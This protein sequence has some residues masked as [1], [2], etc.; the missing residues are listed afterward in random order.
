[1]ATI[2]EIANKLGV[3]K[4]TVSKALKNS[5]DLN[6]DTVA[7]IQKAAAEMG[8]VGRK[9]IDKNN[10]TI[11]LIYPELDD[12]LYASMVRLLIKM[13]EKDGFHCIALPHNFDKT[14]VAE[15]LSFLIGKKVCG[16]FLMADKIADDTLLG[17]RISLSGIPVV[18]IS[19]DDE[20]AAYDNVWINEK[21]G[22]HHVVEHLVSLGHEKIAFIG[23]QYGESRLSCF[24]A[25]LEEHH[26]PMVPELICQTEKRGFSCG[27]EGM[28]V[29]LGA[30]ERFTAIFAQYDAV[31]MGAMRALKK[32]HLR[33]PEDYSLVG[34]DNAEYG[35][36]AT[37]SLSTVNNNVEYLCSLAY[38][39]LK[40][41]IYEKEKETQ[42]VLVSSEFLPRESVGKAK[43]F[44]T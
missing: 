41:K 5:G 24:L 30:K 1:M 17:E 11:G 42:F 7:K 27:Y 33:I 37:P 18:K 13:V 22:I 21:I 32:N 38:K 43:S 19:T 34:F 35:E 20:N 40:N 25:A 44:E 23:D 31:A 36:F 8:Y 2:Q 29:L 28:Q 12:A 6:A 3:N 9:Y 39:L 16:I 10:M 14:K 15:N 26:L 4:S